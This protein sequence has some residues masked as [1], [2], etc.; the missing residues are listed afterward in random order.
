MTSDTGEVV[1]I[2]RNL[3]RRH[4]EFGKVDHV[5]GDDDGRLDDVGTA[6]LSFVRC[7]GGRQRNAVYVSTPITT[8]PAYLD[9]RRQVS[10]T[11][12]ES[13][14]KYRDTLRSQVIEANI[15]RAADI[16]LRVRQRF[17]DHDLVIDPTLLHDVDDWIQSDY[18]RFWS[19][20]VRR[21]ARSVVFVDGWEY[22]TGCTVEF[23]AAVTVGAKLF[24]GS[25]HEI[26]PTAGVQL[27][28]R[29]IDEVESAKLDSTPLK[30]SLRSIEE[31][32]RMASNEDRETPL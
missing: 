11:L 23:A 27:V 5:T 14:A 13:H 18:H 30:R 17:A 20:V 25:F 15:A 21:F 31:A 32:I 7:L 6:L 22:S 26:S 3:P 24:T 28:A 9:W 2:V 16:V 1:G 10:G 4:P 12:D 29:A 19:E 8:G